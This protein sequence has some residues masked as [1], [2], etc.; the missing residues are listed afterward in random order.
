MERKKFMK[1][2]NKIS[3]GIIGGSGFV[4]E[5]LL[6]LVSRHPNI[7]LLGISSREL[8]GLEIN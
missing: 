7:N 5:E 6:G 1:E 3:A 8:V 4:G 2:L